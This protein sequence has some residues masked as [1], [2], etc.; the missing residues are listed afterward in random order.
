MISIVT[1]CKNIISDGREAF[2]R[3]AMET[4]SAQTY[5]DFEH[6]MIDGGSEDG[7]K[8]LLDEY[9][10]SKQID[11]LISE[12]DNGIYEAMNKG[13]RLAK[14]DY[15]YNMNTDDYFTTDQF[16]QR[17]IDAIEK[18]QV[19]FTH[20]DRI[21]K[22]RDGGPDSIKRGDERVAFFRMPFRYQTMLIRKE[23]Y[24][25]FAPLNEKFK[26]AS[27]YEFMLKMIMVDKKGYYFPEVFIC[28]LDGG[29]TKD[30][31]KCI[32]EVTQVL[33][34]CYGEKYGLTLADCENI[35]RKNISSDLLAKVVSQVND[36]RIVESI[37]YCYE[38][39]NH[40]Q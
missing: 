27:D 40:P 2:F 23:V 10:K 5:T 4:L 22:K 6:I 13:L 37:K 20:G 7:T 12:K 21:I 8:D 16:F 36:S 30:R 1:P 26:I 31:Q 34:E 29:I 38:H 39:E 35:Y 11:I 19:D 32:D 25:E 18:Y 28:S 15:V 3:K 33:F 24:D 14:G 17:S 9:V